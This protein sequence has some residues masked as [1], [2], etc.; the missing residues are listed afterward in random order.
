MLVLMRPL[1]GFVVG[2]TADRRWQ[3][4]SELLER[5][6]AS[7]LHGPTITTLYLDCDE[8]LRRRTQQVIAEPPDYVVATTGIGMRAWM[9]TA[10]TWGL[11]E[12]LV[13]ALGT[14]KIVAR[15]PKA[16][17][18]VQAAGLEVW[19]RSST[20]RMDDVLAILLSEPLAG[21]RVVI[22]QYGM[23]TPELTTTLAGVGADVVEVPV[24]RWRLP[25]DK[26][27]AHRLLEAVCEGRVDAITFT[28][29]PAVHN[30]FAI[31]AELELDGQLRRALN[32]GVVAAC[33]GPVCAEGARQE[34]VE[35]PLAPDV[36]RLGLLVRAL[37]DHFASQRKELRLGGCEL[38]VQ[39]S[40]IVVD[41]QRGVLTPRERGVFELLATTPGALVS[42]EALLQRVW[43]SPDVDPHL[44]EVTVGRLRRRLGRCGSAIQ[45]VSGRG[46]RLAP[47]AERVEVG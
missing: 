5:R 32:D 44:L 46:Y 18:A 4:Q 22:Q 25:E 23:E 13:S 14:A 10:D 30:L 27:P 26:G 9:E 17:G 41:G 21:C 31:A 39:G 1:E 2:V 3:E 34:G 40:A 6:G 35:A 16:A 45:A 15:G 42:R 37:S 20:E 47:D 36:G 38:V 33:V 24:Y 12:A 19:A 8:E 43:G 28:S 11:G 7:V 29:A